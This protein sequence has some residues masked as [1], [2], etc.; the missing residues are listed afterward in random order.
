M[1][2]NTKKNFACLTFA[3]KKAINKVRDKKTA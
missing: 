2:N 3:I 1:S